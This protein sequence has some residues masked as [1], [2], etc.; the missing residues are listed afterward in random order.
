MAQ[1]VKIPPFTVAP[2]TV[3]GG[4]PQ[5]TF[6]FDFPF[7]AAADII[8]LIDDVELSPNAYTVT[9]FALQDGQPVEGGY[10]SG[11]V[12]LDADV[13]NVTVTIDRDVTGDRETQFSRSAPLG[14]PALNGDLNRVTARQQDL[15]R[16]KVTRPVGDRAGKFLAFDA[17]GNEVASSGT[18]VDAGLRDDLAD[19]EGGLIQ[20]YVQDGVGAYPMPALVKWRSHLSIDEFIPQEELP[21]IRTLESDYDISAEAWD[22]A[23]GEAMAGRKGLALG[24]GKYRALNDLS[25]VIGYEEAI[26]I[27]GVGDTRT[28]IEFWGTAATN[29]LHLHGPE[30]M[31]SFE[32]GPSVRHLELIG[33]NGA[34]RGLTANNLSRLHL[35]RV[36]AGQFAGCGFKLTTTIMTEMDQVLANG[37]GSLTEGAIE[38]DGGTTLLM[39]HPY[40]SG[41]LLN[42][43]GGKLGGL[44]ID[45][46]P[47]VTILGGAIES[48]GTP[49]MI[50]SKSEASRGCIGGTVDGLDMENPGNGNPFIDIGQG[51]TGDTGF[52]ARGWRFHCTGSASGTTVNEFAVRLKHTT[53]IKF[54]AGC[55][56]AQPGTPTSTYELVGSTNLGVQIE[57]TRGMFNASGSP[58][59]VRENSAMR[60]DATPMMPFLQHAP[61][62][63]YP[64]TAVKSGTSFSCLLSASQGGSYETLYVDNASATNIS[65]IT[66]GRKGMKL[67]L[68]STNGNSTLAHGTGTNAIRTPTGANVAMVQEIPYELWHD[69]IRWALLA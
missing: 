68:L 21:W 18:G 49:L 29:G 60:G 9:G 19:P 16:H 57:P 52:A 7:F 54:E 31:E 20:G 61:T 34:P 55:T 40:I 39:L 3:V 24:G 1:N 2:S 44:L 32:F 53:D 6:A 23:I 45:R 15:A 56:F 41:G 47:H 38:V 59:W 27:V 30:G 26:D 11:Q 43:A 51:W 36:L 63:G 37:C 4:T 25:A 66:G 48:T 12:V 22:N 14:M 13:S 58:P 10:G 50:A 5:S 28:F 64:D 17:G 62:E 46:I 33:S 69:G 67:R 8:V 35:Q 42:G 65:T